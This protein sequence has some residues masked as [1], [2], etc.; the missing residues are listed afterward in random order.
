MAKD[1]LKDPKWV[2]ARDKAMRDAQL[3]EQ[4][5]IVEDPSLAEYSVDLRTT[6]CY[7][8]EEVEGCTY[9]FDTYNIN[10]DCL[11]ND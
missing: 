10:G 4:A 7:T 5:S 2:K 8:C 11:K 6:T 9:A 3:E 1:F